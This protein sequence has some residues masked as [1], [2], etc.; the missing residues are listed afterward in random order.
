[1][2]PGQQK[3]RTLGS[4]TVGT[5]VGKVGCVN[6]AEHS[7]YLWVWVLMLLVTES[8]EVV[9]IHLVFLFP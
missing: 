1:M 6:T 9:L 4:G 3:G 8:E 2:A 7:A 5:V